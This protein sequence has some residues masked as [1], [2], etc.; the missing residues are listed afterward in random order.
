MN[1]VEVLRYS[2][3]VSEGL[4]QNDFIRKAYRLATAPKFFFK[5]LSHAIKA[6]CNTPDTSR[7][8]LNMTNGCLQGYDARLDQILAVKMMGATRIFNVNRLS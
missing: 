5:I 8:I 6:Y 1:A 7:C 4:S 2:L 3:L